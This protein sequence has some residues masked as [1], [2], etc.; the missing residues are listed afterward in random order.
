MSLNESGWDSE[1]PSS[2]AMLTGLNVVVLPTE[3]GHGGELVGLRGGGVVHA[4]SLPVLQL[5]GEVGA[6][7]ADGAEHLTVADRD[8][9]AQAVLHQ[10]RSLVLLEGLGRLLGR[11]GKRLQK[12]KERRR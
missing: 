1:A 10:E 12:R 2:V 4:E 9:Q 8:G 7:Q 5:H 3:G 6:L 11:L